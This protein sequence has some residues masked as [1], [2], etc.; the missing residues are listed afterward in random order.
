MSGRIEDTAIG[1]PAPVL[2]P[3][4]S[5]YAGFRFSGL[6]PGVHV[7][8]PSSDVDLIISLGGPIDLV[9]MPNTTQRPSAFT[10]L[11][12]G[13]QQAPVIVRQTGEAFGVHVFIKPFGVRAVLGVAGADISSIVVN[14]S[15]VW[16]RAG[17]LV[18]MLLAADTWQ[19][20]FTVLD[21]AF[22]S[23]LNST[24]PPREV[25]WAWR[26][27]VKSH[28]GITVQELADGI[29]YSRRHF[30]D[31]FRETIGVTPKLFARVLRFERACRLIA[32]K[33]GCLADV[34]IASG[35]YDQAHLTR[36]WH[37]LAG[38]SPRAWIARDLPFLQDYELGGR[39]N[40]RDGLE[41][42]HQ[43]FV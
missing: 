43:S 7:G 20:R 3:F 15:D 6:P 21:H 13:L 25:S 39:N 4:I 10:A 29:G 30:S 9:Q 24:N 5:Q 34:A 36:E 28:G 40:E 31:R 22:A 41:S 32:D 35:Y 38:C 19:E 11:V 26:R 23:K 12:G 27:L 18:E 42:E 1:L 17:E 33:E 16:A 14:L 2:R 37:A 8:L